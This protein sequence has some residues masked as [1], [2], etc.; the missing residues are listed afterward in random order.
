MSRRLQPELRAWWW[1]GVTATDCAVSNKQMHSTLHA[2]CEGGTV[3]LWSVC[4]FHLYL[5]A[6][7]DMLRLVALPAT[8]GFLWSCPKKLLCLMP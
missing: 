8:K 1:T 2:A 5:D 7:L 6:G 4:H 3:T